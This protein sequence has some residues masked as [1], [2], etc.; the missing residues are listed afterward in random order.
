MSRSLGFNLCRLA[1]LGVALPLAGC[2]GFRQALGVAKVSPDEFAVVTKAPLVIPPDYALKPPAPGAGPTSDT[3]ELAAQ[4]A[5]IGDVASNTGTLSAGERALLNDAGAQH[6]DPMIRKVIDQEYAGIVDR[7]R[8]FADRL[9][10]WSHPNEAKVAEL[11]AAQE[12]RRLEEHPPGVKPA[13][14]TSSASADA[15]SAKSEARVPAMGPAKP[16]KV[17]GQ[18]TPTI[19]AK[20]RSRLLDGIF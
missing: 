15:T 20:K 6:A 7:D 11:D 13:A 2:T 5:L 9:I 19:G 4:R 1:L 18:E 16:D 8:S 14:D 12:A 10:F 3:S 17:E